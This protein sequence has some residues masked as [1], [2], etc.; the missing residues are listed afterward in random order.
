MTALVSLSAGPAVPEP[1]DTEKMPGTQKGLPVY[2]DRGGYVFR[3][4][5][6]PEGNPF[7]VPDEPA[8]QP[9]EKEEPKE[10]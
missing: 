7:Y 4:F 9:E 1:P 10:E 2:A 5:E 3:R 6:D 8:E